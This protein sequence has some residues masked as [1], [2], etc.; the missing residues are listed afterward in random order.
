MQNCV[1]IMLDYDIN[2]LFYYNFY[3]RVNSRS[4]EVHMNKSGNMFLIQE[5]LSFLVSTLL[6]YRGLKRSDFQ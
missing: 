5:N 3:L 1:I 2:L 4:Y 6:W